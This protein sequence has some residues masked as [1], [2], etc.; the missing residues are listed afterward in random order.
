MIQ[1][2]LRE[3]QS[4]SRDATGIVVKM[5]GADNIIPLNHGRLD[6]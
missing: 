2:L 1:E 4:N 6:W 5:K 3:S